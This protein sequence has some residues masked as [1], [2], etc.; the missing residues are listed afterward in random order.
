MLQ[1]YETEC[2]GFLINIFDH[3]NEESGNVI[4]NINI[5]NFFWYTTTYIL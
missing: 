2:E 5:S 4:K 3:I 1:E